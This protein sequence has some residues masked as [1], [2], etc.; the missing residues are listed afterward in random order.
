MIGFRSSSTFGRLS[1][2]DRKSTKILCSFPRRIPMSHI[3]PYLTH[4]IT[5]TGWYIP[6]AAVFD[7]LSFV[8]VGVCFFF[9]IGPLW[10]LSLGVWPGPTCWTILFKEQPTHQF[11]GDRDHLR[12][13]M[14]REW[15]KECKSVVI[16]RDF[17][18]IVHCLG[19]GCHM[20]WPLDTQ[21]W[22]ALEEV[23][24]A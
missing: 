2:N 17:H 9:G 14:A 6:G 5:L 12:K 10:I 1:C 4:H 20:T 15:I 11:F 8:C 13:P 16:L 23:T 19:Q 24:P 7:L 21:N 3:Y 22:L 18:W